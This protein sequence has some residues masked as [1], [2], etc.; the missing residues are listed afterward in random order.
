MFSCAAR[1]GGGGGLGLL[2]GC[3]AARV[4]AEQSTPLYQAVPVLQNSLLELPGAEMSP[5]S[6]LRASVDHP[7]SILLSSFFSLGE[8]VARR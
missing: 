3:L 7:I 5:L 2:F 1:N 8:T 6:R 4:A